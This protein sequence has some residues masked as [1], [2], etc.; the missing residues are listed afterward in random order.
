MFR[1][2]HPIPFP[3]D[4]DSDEIVG[5]VHENLHHHD[6]QA[7]MKGEPL[8]YTL[9]GQEIFYQEEDVV[10]PVFINEAGY[11]EKNIALFLTERLELNIE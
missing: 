6:Y 8:F 4:E 7:L 1:I 9:E 3:K 2:K 5:M 10:Y 11:Y